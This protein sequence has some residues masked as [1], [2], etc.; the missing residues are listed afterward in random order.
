MAGVEEAELDSKGLEMDAELPSSEAPILT[1][2]EQPPSDRAAIISPRICIVFI[3]FR[4]CSVQRHH[5]LVSASSKTL[6]IFLN[7]RV[8]NRFGLIHMLEI[9]LRD[10]RHMDRIMDKHVVPGAILGRATLGH[11]LIPLFVQIELGILCV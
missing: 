9:A 2:I 1:E 11:L 3:G 7:H 4:P 8:A 6:K 5:G 10:I